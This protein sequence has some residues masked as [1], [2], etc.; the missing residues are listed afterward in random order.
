MKVA[1][2]DV[3][4]CGVSLVEVLVVLAILAI[5]VGMLVP[6]VQR[7]RASADNA[8]CRNNLRQIGLGLHLYHDAHKRFPFV[9]SCPAP[10][11]GG[12][13]PQCLTCNPANTYTGPHETWWCPYDNRP[14]STLTAALATYAP[15]GSLTP[16]VENALPI[17][18]CPDALDRTSGSPTQGAY[19]QIGY[20]INPDVGGKTLKEARGVLVFEHDDLPSCR[21]AAEHFT[22][23][24]ADAATKAARHSPP[25]HSGQA[26]HLWY[27]GSV[28]N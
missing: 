1:E 16:F 24:P 8:V 27:D 4:R 19:F 18:R 3:R 7:V 13:D 14:G 22:A 15:A 20:A 21:G 11:K 25:R 23:W 9:R 12:G 5:M 2:A 10:W 26:N 28:P 17:F 6:A